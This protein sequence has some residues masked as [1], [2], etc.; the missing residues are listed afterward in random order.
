MEELENAK[1]FYDDFLRAYD[2]LIIEVGRRKALESKREEII[3]DTISKLQ[4]L[5]EDDLTEREE[6][7]REHGQFIPIDIWPGLVD[8]PNRYR[9]SAEEAAIEN[10]PDISKSVIHRA[11]RRVHG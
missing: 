10:V 4:L 6:F 1:S 5:Y 3:Q 2:S 11:I 7:K 9:V 8:S